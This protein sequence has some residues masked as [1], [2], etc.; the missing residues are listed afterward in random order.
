MSEERFLEL[1]PLA[2]LGALD[3]EDRAALESQLGSTPALQRELEVYQELVGRL[4]LATAPVPPSA[5]LRERLL[6]ATAPGREASR[7]W[8]M[9]TLAAALLAALF[10]AGVLWSQ[11]QAARRE[12]AFER[13]AAQEAREIAQ[14]AQA[15]AASLREALAVEVA[16]RELVIRPESRVVSLAGL[17]PALAAHGHV[18]WHA[19]RREAVLLASGLAPAPAGKAYELWI[20]AKGAPV[21]AG[22]FQAD[23]QG[24]VVFH[25]PAGLE[26]A[27][28]RTFAVTVEPEAGTQAPTGPMVLAGAVS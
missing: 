4:G 16:F 27:G 20:I 8:L 18:V 17:A 1:V 12:A 2:A 23:A 14:K 25:L 9:P 19:E 5:F 22:V 28:V 21:P 10:G 13:A 7:S 26:L 11:R 3:A 6:R 15:E 24:R